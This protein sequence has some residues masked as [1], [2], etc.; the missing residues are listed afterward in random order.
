AVYQVTGWAEYSDTEYTEGSPLAVTEGTTVDL[1]NNS[2]S[3]IDDHL[4]TGV[5]SLYDGTVITPDTVGDSYELAIRFKTKS[6]IN[7]GAVRVSVNIGGAIG[8]ITAD[9]RRL[10]KG[11]SEENTIQINFSIYSLSTFI[12]NGGTVKFEAVAGNQSVY[13]IRYIITRTHKGIA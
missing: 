3:I 13:G 5:S 7:D 10:N 6:S 12:A 4:P 1:P 11:S 9:S 2:G 8:E